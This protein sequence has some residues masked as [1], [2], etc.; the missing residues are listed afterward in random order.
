MDPLGLQAAI[1]E[2]EADIE[3]LE[4]LGATSLKA[5]IDYS[6]LK[7]E[8]AGQA[9]IDYAVKTAQGHPITIKLG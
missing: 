8:A 3:K 9:L 7:F 5:L 6:A 4:G 1:K 2:A